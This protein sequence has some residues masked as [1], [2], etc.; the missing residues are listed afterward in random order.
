MA[1]II[2]A[3]TSVAIPLPAGATLILSG[4]GTA[5]AAPLASATRLHVLTLAQQQIGPVSMARTV[6]VVAAPG[7]P[8]VT[9]TMSPSP[10]TLY[11]NLRK[12]RGARL[13]SGSVFTT[14]G[15]TAGTT[16]HTTLALPVPFTAIQPVF[17]NLETGAI[18]ISKCCAAAVSAL[19]DGSNHC[20]PAATYTNVTFGGATAGVMP[21]RAAASQPTVFTGDLTPLQSVAATDGSGMYYVAVRTYFDVAG[22]GSG[23]GTG[24]SYIGSQAS[25]DT[26]TA[27]FGGQS[28]RTSAQVV[29]GVTTPANMT[30]GAANGNQVLAGVIYRCEDG[31][32]T[33][34]CVGDSTVRGLNG[35]S[36]LTG[37]FVRATGALSI[38]PRPI[39]CVNVGCSGALPATYEA[40]AE[41]YLAILKPAAAIYRGSSINEAITTQAIADSHMSLAIRF[42][43]FCQQNSILPILETCMP[44]NLG[45][46]AADALRQAFNVRLMAYAT[47]IG[48][49]Y[50]DASAAVCDPTVPW[51]YLPAYDSG[52]H[53][54]PGDTGYGVIQAAEQ[55]VL[56]QY[57]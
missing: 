39:T 56:A 24:Y 8:G 16:W 53:S 22:G 43:D 46:V 32:L 35:T 41:R 40:N 21:A 29:D 30:S 26:A 14:A 9:Y 44:Q 47:S 34:A 36:G 19:L 31:S 13:L 7:G 45:S 5:Q 37:G 51:Q 10:D 12:T 57:A 33:V 48:I 55:L 23:A 17:L 11:P 4:Q 3:G 2:P 52:D 54:H 27:L 38:A 25:P 15:T 49:P 6:L 42:V 18:T 20:W 50:V 1:N 28:C